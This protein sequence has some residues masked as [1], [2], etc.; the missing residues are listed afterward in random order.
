VQQE[1][2]HW[3]LRED[4]KD[5]VEPA[6]R[7]A[8]RVGLVNLEEAGS[9]EVARAMEA[10]LDK[11]SHHLAQV[12]MAPILIKWLALYSGQEFFKLISIHFFVLFSKLFTKKQ[13]LK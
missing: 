8:C 3:E 12:I 13:D 10:F 6:T 2:Y 5:L 1:A 9:L 4:C 7:V 11:G